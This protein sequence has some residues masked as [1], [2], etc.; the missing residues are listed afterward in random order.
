MNCT[1]QKI[2]V[3]AGTALYFVYFISVSYHSTNKLS[4]HKIA[5]FKL[6]TR[7]PKYPRATPRPLQPVTSLFSEQTMR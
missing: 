7:L 2:L 6:A 1:L 3:S 5:V 4:I